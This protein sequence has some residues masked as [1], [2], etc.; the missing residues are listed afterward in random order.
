MNHRYD[1]TIDKSR[2]EVYRVK[3]DFIEIKRRDGSIRKIA[4]PIE[5]IY[6]ESRVCSRKN[7]LA[8][9]IDVI[10]DVDI[11]IETTK[12]LTL[13]DILIEYPEYFFN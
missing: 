10:P 2:F 5:M 13:D 6:P 7:P 9:Q 3:R 11:E 4:I 1:K 8:K 12:Y